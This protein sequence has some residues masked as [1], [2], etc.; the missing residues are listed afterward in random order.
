MKIEIDIPEENEALIE[1]FMDGVNQC[2]EFTTHGPLD[3]I[4]LA[5][6]L[7]EDVALSV[8]RPGSWEGA[9]MRQVLTSH[10]YNQ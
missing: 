10:G 2:G 7:M 5:E 9:N 4:V 1:Q 8:S 6:M 3:M